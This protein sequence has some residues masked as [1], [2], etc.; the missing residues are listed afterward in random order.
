MI[1]L[2]TIKTG[3]TLPVDLL[4]EVDSFMRKMNLR[5]RSKVIAEALRIYLDDRKFLLA[6][7]KRFVGSI[8]IIYNHERGETLERLV[9]IQHNYLDLISS[10]LHMHLTHEKCLEVLLFKGLRDDIKKLVSDIENI[11]GVDLVRIIAVGHEEA[12]RH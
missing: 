7:N 3:I 1:F 4:E 8:F 10:V 11:T 5:S 6:E 12:H 2:K 9:D